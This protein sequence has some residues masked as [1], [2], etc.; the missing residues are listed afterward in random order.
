MTD[1]GERFAHSQFTGRLRLAFRESIAKE[2]KKL[3]SF[4]FD[5][6]LYCFFFVAV[7]GVLCT[8]PWIGDESGAHCAQLH[9]DVSPVRYVC[10]AIG[11]TVNYLLGK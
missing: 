4:C 2:V 6:V 8:V 1:R 7:V 10:V 11:T 5:I 3:F 9:S